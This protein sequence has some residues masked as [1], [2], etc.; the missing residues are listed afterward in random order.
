MR[1]RF[2]AILMAMMMAAAM[3]PAM[4]MTEE[5]DED[6]QAQNVSQEEPEA[7]MQVASAV[8]TVEGLDTA[9]SVKS[10]SSYKDDVTV[11]NAFGGKV[12]LVYE[13]DVIQTIDIPEAVEN[14]EAGFACALDYGKTWWKTTGNQYQVKVY[15]AGQETPGYTGT[16][17]I[18]T[19]RYYQ[20]PSQY[21]QIQDEITLTGG[22]YVLKS[23]YMGLKVKKVNKYFKTGN[24]GHWPRYTSKTKAKVKNFQKKKGIKATGNVDLETW[25]AMGFS[26][27]EWNNLGAYVTPSKVDR[28][29]SR[30]DCVDAMIATANSYIGASY[31]VGASGTKNQGC[32]CSGFV[33]QCMYGAGVGSSTINPVT[34]SKKGHEYESRNL[35]KYSKLKTVSYSDRKKGD[36]IFY[37]YGKTVYHVALYIG[38]N[39]IIHSWPNKV[40]KS[41][42]S[43]W[44]NVL[45]VK[46]VFN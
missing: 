33:M 15:A 5:T 37:G 12:E 21:L 34:H 42:V 46:R 19:L 2:L 43:G 22:D 8:I 24:Y 17:T 29:S 6:V 40:R 30:A 27:N 32:D 25:L 45:K 26:E 23:G 7:E 13:G 38:D 1:R 11:Y 10:R 14:P 18:E 4:A 41:G 16:V 3:T 39:K 20:N 36:L 28:S 31:V 44:G 9:P 35:A